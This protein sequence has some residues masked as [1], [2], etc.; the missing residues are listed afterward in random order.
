MKN[1]Q[2]AGYHFTHHDIHKNSNANDK[3]EKNEI[4]AKLGLNQQDF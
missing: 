3:Y 4:L 1:K 2:T